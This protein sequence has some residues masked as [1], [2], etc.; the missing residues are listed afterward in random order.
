MTALYG[1]LYDTAGTVVYEQLL[2]L[3]C[4]PGKNKHDKKETSRGVVHRD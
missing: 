4:G 1:P 3:L 2:F